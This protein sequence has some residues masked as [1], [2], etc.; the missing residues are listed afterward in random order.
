MWKKVLTNVCDE[1][2]SQ[3]LPQKRGRTFSEENTMMKFVTNITKNVLTLYLDL[4]VGANNR[5]LPRHSYWRSYS[6]ISQQ[7][8]LCQQKGNL[9]KNKKVWEPPGKG[10]CGRLICATYPCNSLI[11]NVAFK[12]SLVFQDQLY[13]HHQINYSAGH[14]TQSRYNEDQL[15][16]VLAYQ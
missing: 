11:Y 12:V 14:I 13:L 10:F 8:V 1:F 5:Q 6:Q 15:K 2:R 3:C 7:T 9:S 16:Y 4:Y